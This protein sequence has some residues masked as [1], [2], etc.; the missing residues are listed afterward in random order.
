MT[1]KI[2]N[3][4]SCQQLKDV[5]ADAGFIPLF[6]NDIAG[7]SV[8]ELTDS[9]DWWTGIPEKDP[10]AWRIMLTADDDVAYGK[11]FGGKAGF[12]SKAWFPFFASYRRDGYDFDARY[13]D[14][15]ASNRCKAI[16]DLFVDRPV[17]ASYDIKALAGFGRGGMP[18]FEGALTHLQMN[19]YLTISR[20][21]QKRNKA[22]EGYGWH[23]AVYSTAEA[24]FGYDCVRS[25]YHIV[26]EDA[27]NRLVSRVMEI[28]PDTAYDVAEKIIRG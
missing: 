24:K 19:T 21:E 27:K 20:L 6:R 13:E 22:G 26:A 12:I 16:M 23:A 11:L 5:I 28:R 15:K 4:H 3:I 10:W 2:K 25:Q 9:A 17:I 7:F 14:G 18:G 8:Q 1:L